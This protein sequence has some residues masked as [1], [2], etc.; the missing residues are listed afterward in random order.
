MNNNNIFIFN[1]I[2]DQKIY[3]SLNL[4]AFCWIL[5][6]R[7]YYFFFYRSL[8]G[9]VYKILRE[10]CVFSCILSSN[11]FSLMISLYIFSLSLFFILEVLIFWV[12]YLSWCIMWFWLKI[13]PTLF[14]L[15]VLAF[16]FFFWLISL[17]IGRSS[18]FFY[19]NGN[20]SPI[21]A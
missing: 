16:T 7:F 2:H 17:L 5:S 15:L 14:F 9:L 20:N 21:F 3:F 10:C 1:A 13:L 18:I 11:N 6:G 4:F 12:F 19:F 8:L